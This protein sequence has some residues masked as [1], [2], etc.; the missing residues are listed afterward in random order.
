MHAYLHKSWLAGTQVTRKNLSSLSQERGNQKL[1]KEPA[2]D[3]KLSSKSGC[4]L[5][6]CDKLARRIGKMVFSS[7]YWK[8][9]LPINDK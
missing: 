3:T 1:Q 4:H 8:R 5:E 2:I 6:A 9:D 7:V